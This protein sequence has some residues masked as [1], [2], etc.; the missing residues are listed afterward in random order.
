MDYVLT[1]LISAIV[2]FATGWFFRKKN[3]NGTDIKIN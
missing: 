1:A 3:P 2:G